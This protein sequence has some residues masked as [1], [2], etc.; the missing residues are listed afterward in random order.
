[1]K[2]FPKVTN[3]HLYNNQKEIKQEIILNLHIT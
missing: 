3:S 1:M 2:V